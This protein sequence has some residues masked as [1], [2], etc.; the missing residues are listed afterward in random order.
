MSVSSS[1]ELMA[2]RSISTELKVWPEPLDTPGYIPHHLKRAATSQFPIIEVLQ[3][4]LYRLQPSTDLEKVLAL[5]AI[6]NATQPLFR[7]IKDLFIWSFTVQL[8]IPEVD[9]V[10]KEVMGWMSSEVLAKH[11]TRSAMITSGALYDSNEGHQN[12]PFGPRHHQNSKAR[13]DEVQCLRPPIGKRIFWV[14]YRPFLFSRAGGEVSRRS[15]G[16][17]LDNQG[18]LQNALTITTLG[19]NLKP[20]Q[21]FANMCREHKLKNLTG[22]TTVYFAES[23]RGTYNGVEWASI[24]KAVRRL[25]TID[26][27]EKTKTDIVRDAE[28]YYSEQ[29][30]QFFAD[31]GIPYRRGYLLHGPP[32]TG[33]SSFSAALAG[34]LRC[35]IYLIN[36]AAGDMNDGRLHRLFLSLPR[37]CI[38]VIED[39]DSAGINREQAGTEAVVSGEHAPLQSITQALRS[40][41]T[42]SGL[43]NAIDGNASQE[44][45]LLIMTSNHPDAL[46]PAL[47][48][49]GRI[50]KNIYFGNMNKAAAKSIFL[51]LIGQSALAHDAAFTMSQIE[52]DAAEF[53]EKVPPNVFTPAQVQNFLHGCRGNPQKALKEI[54][55]WVE[56]NLKSGRRRTS[57][58]AILVD[59]ESEK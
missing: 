27:D 18:E 37:K 20:L 36:L 47:L 39:V 52:E 25:D 5:V 58:S 35:D 12:H 3:R 45:R 13:E 11:Y 31:C 16:N 29:S 51:R 49:P 33:K 50:D 30:R 44:G 19:W 6:Y 7:H 2:P 9:P 10:A 57:D 28:Y 38:V 42:L 22:T 23:G 17:V 1:T 34:H 14:G 26:M 48:R 43:L 59:R 24:S 54:D 53:A 46:D 4:I 21:D 40:V 15:G 8:T 32:G 55:A 56:E 41:V